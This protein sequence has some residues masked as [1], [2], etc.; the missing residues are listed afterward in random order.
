MCAQAYDIAAVKFR[1][2]EAVTNFDIRSYDVHV[3]QLAQVGPACI[4]RN[5]RCCLANTSGGSLRA[6]FRCVQAQLCRVCR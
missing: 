3:S 5:Q 4:G 2:P 1:G 6:W